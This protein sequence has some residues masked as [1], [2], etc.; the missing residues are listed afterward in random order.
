MIYYQFFLLGPTTESLSMAPFDSTQKKESCLLFVKDD[1]MKHI[2][3]LEGMQK[4]KS[5]P[6]NR[7]NLIS[8]TADANHFINI[9]QLTEGKYLVRC[10]ITACQ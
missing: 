3:I 9:Y 8:N 1:C 5:Q 2:G 10:Y 4:N 7:L 6:G